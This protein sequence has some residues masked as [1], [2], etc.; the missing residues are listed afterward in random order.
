MRGRPAVALLVEMSNS[1]ARGMLHGIRRYIREHRPWTIQ[2]VERSRDAAPPLWLR[3]W[4]GDGIIARISG[5]RIA[6]AVL[7]TGAPA[8]DIGSLQLVP[9]LPSVETDH[10]AIGRLAAEHLVERGFKHF[11]FRGMG[12]ISWSEARGLHFGRA[13]AEGGHAC[14]ALAPPPTR[15]RLDP[16]KK[17]RREVARWVRALPKPVGVLAAWDGCG[18]EVLEVCQRLGVAVPDELA[19]LGVD[20]DDLLCDLADPPM[21]SVAVDPHQIGYRAAT[22]LDRMMAGQPVD[23]GPYLVKPLGVVS[24]QSTDVLAID[25]RQVSEAVRFIREHATHGINV[26][27]VLAA[28]P[29]S[30]RVLEARFKKTLDITP[31]EAI[32]RARLRRAQELLAE[33]DLPMHV[34]AERSG[35]HYP[36]YMAMVFRKRLG[37]TPG[38]FRAEKRRGG[39]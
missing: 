36:E 20:N 35:F 5:P 18:V 25:D 13:L 33:T 3:R 17:D 27:D 21:S 24:R 11:G 34:V 4:R 37:T 7:A 29:L 10:E 16:W 39:G 30:R 14:S 26:E 8:V 9:G 19:V 1:H 12:G 28:V 23:A 15:G 32:V 38:L 31:H 2:F 6:E 22:L